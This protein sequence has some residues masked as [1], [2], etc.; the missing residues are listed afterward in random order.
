[1]PVK[2]TFLYMTFIFTSGVS[3]GKWMIR[4]WRRKKDIP[5]AFAAKCSD[6]VTTDG[7]T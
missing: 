1:M 3:E 2:I 5:S 6:I 4:V 7:Y